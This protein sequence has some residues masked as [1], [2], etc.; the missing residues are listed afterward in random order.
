MGDCG[1]KCCDYVV[2]E[3]EKFKRQAEKLEKELRWATVDRDHYQAATK[4]RDETI[5]T[6]ARRIR[7]FEG[8]ATRR[9]NQ[10]RAERL[11]REAS[12]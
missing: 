3:L 8:A 6:M 7:S 11:A 2:F 9:K 1:C 4:G 5:A 10:Q 12:K